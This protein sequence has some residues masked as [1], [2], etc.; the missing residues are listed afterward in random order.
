M[1][2]SLKQYLTERLQSSIITDKILNDKGGM[3]KFYKVRYYNVYNKTISNHAWDNALKLNSLLYNMVDVLYKRD[4]YNNYSR[5]NNIYVNGKIIELTEE[6]IKKAHTLYIKRYNKLMNICKS[7]FTKSNGDLLNIILHHDSS[8]KY[9]Y[10]KDYASVNISN[11]TDDMFKQF[12]YIDIKAN[13]QLY[14]DIIENKSEVVIMYFSS[15]NTLEA[16]Q[17]LQEIQL[18]APQSFINDDYLRHLT[19]SDVESLI[20]GDISIYTKGEFTDTLSDGT[21]LTYP[22]LTSTGNFSDTLIERI[23][24]AICLQDSDDIPK[25]KPGKFLSKASKLQKLTNWGKSD[26]DYV[27]IYSPIK[28]AN[29][30]T[31]YLQDKGSRKYDQRKIVDTYVHDRFKWL[32][33]IFD[34]IIP[35]GNGTKSEKS[36]KLYQFMNKVDRWYIRSAYEADEYCVQM[37]KANEEKYA[38]LK[39]TIRSINE[40]KGKNIEEQYTILQKELQNYINKGNQYNIKIKQNF[41]KPNAE[42]TNIVELYAAYSYVLNDFIKCVTSISNQLKKINTLTNNILHNAKIG[43]IQ[44]LTHDKYNLKTQTDALLK[45]LSDVSSKYSIALNESLTKL[46]DLLK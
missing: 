40:I 8:S 19:R 29:Q 10:G 34:E 15:D 44:N 2:F 25:F 9:N 46:D 33:N 7:L 11:I 31:N 1:K 38:A 27:L 14:K 32:Y 22:I 16:V 43:N 13:P 26:D 12:T 39:E 23:K 35:Y 5:Q 17:K 4:Y 18:I 21:V 37:L 3:C 6:K 28:S 41:N 20:S 24:N 45:I 36:T 42:L 30:Y